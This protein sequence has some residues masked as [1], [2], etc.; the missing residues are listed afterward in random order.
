VPVA[1]GAVGGIADSGLVVRLT[2]SRL[3]IG[4]LAS[5]LVGIVALNVMALSFSASS[6]QAARQ[7]DELRQANSALRGDI[8]TLQSNDKIAAAAADL[9]LATP[10][11]GDFRYLRPSADDAATAAKRLRAGEFSGYVPPATT[12]AAT[13]P[14][15][16]TAPVAEE[17]VAPVEPATET[18]AVE[19]APVTETQAP[20]AATGG[21]VTP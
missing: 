2:R 11:P 9:G 18:A 17:T 8:A 7:A 3:W 13:P 12:V 16:E 21:G 10:G 20:V 1:V 14:A 4:L 5:M 6:S 19:T 15:T